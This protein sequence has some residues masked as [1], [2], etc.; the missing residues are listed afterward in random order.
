M[1][2]PDSNK[3]GIYVPVLE[4][5]PSKYIYVTIQVQKTMILKAEASFI[6]FLNY[7]QSAKYCIASEEDLVKNTQS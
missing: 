5:L 2:V 3:P 7:T 6:L 4:T 1:F